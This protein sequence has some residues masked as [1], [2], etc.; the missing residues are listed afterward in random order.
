MLRPLL[1]LILVSSG[2]TVAQNNVDAMIQ[3]SVEANQRDWDAAPRF[4]YFERDR[5]N[6]GSKTYEEIM[7]LGSPYERL[8]ALNGKPLT[9]AQLAD[10]SRKLENV[11]S[12]RQKESAQKK[13]QRIA[14][15]EAERKRDHSLMG[16]LVK[17][18][19]FKLLTKTR[20]NGYDV[21]V[22][23][24]TPRPEYHP[25]NLETQVLTG[26]QGRLWIDENT[27]Q[28]VKVEAQVTRPVSIVG[29]LAK[30]EPGTHFELEKAPV[31]QG[32]WLP[33]H[34]SMRSRAEVLSCFT[35]KAKRRKTTSTT[36]KGVPTPGTIPSRTNECELVRSHY[37]L[38]PGRRCSMP[39]R[40]SR[41]NRLTV[42]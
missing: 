37:C 9:S 33:K 24:A 19:D 28:W 14:K 32:V 13:A 35:T 29:F 31:D 12:G 34:F 15:Y 41:K 38:A 21:Y 10:E 6:G 17:A 7:I 25:P 5:G 22:L 11:V 39:W 36:T 2:W 1:A 4:D 27:F 20:L 23:Q 8:V 3:R 16:E 26:M 40:R 18:F 42:S 30:V